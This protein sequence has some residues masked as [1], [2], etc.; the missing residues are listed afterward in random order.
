MKYSKFFKFL[1]LSSSFSYF[2]YLTLKL[3][4]ILIFSLIL[5]Q[6]KKWDYRKNFARD[7]TLS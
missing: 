7:L 1:L 2:E 6:R 3:I 5:D 4:Y